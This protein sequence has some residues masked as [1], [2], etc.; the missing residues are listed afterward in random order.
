MCLGVFSLQLAASSLHLMSDLEKEQA[1]GAM[2]GHP[3]A[4]LLVYLL[5]RDYQLHCLRLFFI[6]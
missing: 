1:A 2:R 4:A 5:Q 3:H 6:F